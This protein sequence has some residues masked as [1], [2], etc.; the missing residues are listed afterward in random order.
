[1]KILFHCDLEHSKSH[2]PSF[3]QRYQPISSQCSISV[4][5][6]K[7]TDVSIGLRKTYTYNNIAILKFSL[8][9]GLKEI[10]LV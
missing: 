4:P 5:L 9:Q 6:L 8:T 2:R 3:I 1:M 7:I 10:L